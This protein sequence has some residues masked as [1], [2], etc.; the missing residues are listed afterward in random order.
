VIRLRAR[1][2]ARARI[3]VPR[4]S[5]LKTM[6]RCEKQLVDGAQA[7][8]KLRPD[9]IFRSGISAGHTAPVA[10][11]FHQPD[12][13]GDQR[14]V[15]V[16]AFFPAQ[17]GAGAIRCSLAHHQW[18]ARKVRVANC[19][20]RGYCSQRLAPVFLYLCVQAVTLL[21]AAGHRNGRL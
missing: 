20:C 13:V 7:I 10:M 3:V 2:R 21:N 11:L 19:H 4:K 6:S 9:R 14:P 12:G 16:G 17:G 1:A 18:N 8:R 15:S 5:S